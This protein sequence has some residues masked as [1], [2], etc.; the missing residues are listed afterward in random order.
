MSEKKR[1]LGKLRLPL[2][3]QRNKFHDSHLDRHREREA[4]ADIR[5]GI[6]DHDNAGVEEAPEEGE[7]E[8]GG[9]E[10]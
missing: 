8:Y 4:A 6:E 5:E 10:V 7:E 2:P 3:R 1:K 9:S